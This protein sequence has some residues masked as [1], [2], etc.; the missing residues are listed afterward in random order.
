MNKKIKALMSASLLTTSVLGLSAQSY[1]SLWNTVEESSAKDQPRQ[2]FEDAMK[3]YM[4]AA[5]EG[6]FPQMMKAWIVVSE[7]KCI[8][9]ADSF[10]IEILPEVKCKTP[11]EHSVYNAI[12]G[13][14][15]LAMCGASTIAYDEDTQQ[16]YR[17]KSAECFRNALADKDALVAAKATDYLPVVT[18]GANSR[19][20]GNDMYSVITMFVADY[21]SWDDDSVNVILQ[22]A[23]QYYKEHGNLNAS[24]LM[25]LNL[26]KR[27]RYDMTESCYLTA[28][29]Q[30]MNESETIEAGA[31]VAAEYLDAMDG[32]DVSEDDRWQFV[33]HAQDLFGKSTLK[34]CFV[35]AENEMK[36]S[37]CRLSYSSCRDADSGNAS[38]S[39]IYPN[40]PFC[41]KI[42]YENL[43]SADVEIREYDGRDNKGE[44][45]TSG[46]LVDKRH[47]ILGTDSTCQSRRK[48]GMPYEGTQ[49]ETVSLTAGRYVTVLK[50]NGKTSVD[51]L[52]VSSLCILALEQPR[53]KRLFIVVDNKTGKPISGATLHM[54]DRKDN[55]TKVVCDE[56]GRYFCDDAKIERI[57]ASISDNDQLDKN[58]IRVYSSWRQH[59]L[60]R[61]VKLYTDRTIYRPGQTVHVSGMVYTGDGKGW[62]NV[63]PNIK[64]E[65]KLSDVNGQEVECDTLKSNEW[66]TFDTE[67]VLPKDRLPGNYSIAISINGSC[68]ASDGI[69]VEEYKRPT[70]DVTAKSVDEG[71]E[72]AFGD[73]VQVRISAQTFAGVP[74]QGAAVKYIVESGTGRYRWHGDWEQTADGQTS[75]DSNGEAVVTFQTEADTTKLE[76]GDVVGYRLTAEVTDI[77]GETHTAEYR[78][79]LSGLGFSLQLPAKGKVDLS[80]PKD[81]LTVKALNPND[82]EMSVDGTYKIKRNNSESNSG[83][84]YNDSRNNN[85]KEMETVAEGPFETGKPISLASL[86]MGTYTIEVSA[87]DSHGHLVTTQR[88]YDI[89][90]SEEAVDPRTKIKAAPTSFDDNLYICSQPTFSESKPCEVLLAPCAD[91]I[92]V[93]YYI[94]SDSTVFEQKQIQ[95]NRHLYRFDIDYKPEYGEAV[96][97]VLAFVRNGQTFTKTQPI[98]YQRSDNRLQL[99]WKTFRDNLMPGQQE[100]WIL[101]V[102]DKDGNSVKAAEMMATMYDASLDQLAA[103]SWMFNYS[104]A[105]YYSPYLRFMGQDVADNL[106]LNFPAKN[107]TWNDHDYDRLMPFEYDGNGYFGFR[108]GRRKDGIMLS[109]APLMMSAKAVNLSMMEEESVGNAVDKSLVGRIAG[110]DTN[111]AS[112]NEDTAGT[113]AGKVDMSAS[114]RM[115]S[116]FNETA[117]FYP[118]LTTDADGDVHIAFTLPESLTTWRLLGMV[119]TKDI[120]YGLIDTTC[121]A[122]KNFMVQPN[123]PRFVRE[124]DKVSIVSRVIN[125]GTADLKSRVLFCLLDAESGKVVHNETKT[126]SV[127]A[128]QTEPVAFDYIVTD[129]YPLLVCEITAEAG[130]CSDGERNY[131]PVLTAKQYVTE[132]VPFYISGSESKTVDLSTLFN[133]NSPSATQRCMTLEYTANPACTVIEAL[134]GISVPDN[135][136]AISHAASLYA[137]TVASRLAQSIPGFKE[138]LEKQRNATAGTADAAKSASSG[139]KS[140]S[141]SEVNSVSAINSELADNERM[142]DIVLRESPW[143]RDAL[144][145]SDQ[146]AA[147]LDLFDENLM[148]QRTASAKEKL[149]DLQNADGSWSWFDGMAGS[150]YVTL[151]VCED[152]ALLDPDDSEVQ[153][154]L[155]RGMK[156]LDKEMYRLYNETNSDKTSV[157]N[158]GMHYLFV[159]SLLPDRHVSKDIRKMREEWLGKVETSVRDLTIYGK[160]NCACFLRTFGHTEVADEFLQSV[161]EYSVIK[162]GMGRYYATDAAYYSWCDYRIPTQL[163]VMRAV[164]QSQLADKETVLADMQVWLLRQK[165]TQMWD[166]PM[167][168]ISA[169][170]YLLADSANLADAAVP[171]FRMDG[172]NISTP[173]DTTKF[174]AQQLGYVHTEIDAQLTANGVTKLEIVPAKNNALQNGLQ[175]ASQANSQATSQSNPQATSQSNSQA[176]LQNLS[177]ISWGAV[178]ARFLENMDRLKTQSSG[179]LKIARRLLVD[180]KTFDPQTSMLKVGDRVTVRIT[181]TADRD[182]DFVQVHL[183][184]PACFESTD[185]SSGYRWMNGRGGYVAR[186]DASTDLFFDKFAK[187]N[188]TLDIDY[189]VTRTGEYLTGAATVQ[190]AYA[191]EF[192]GHTGS[193]SVK[194][195]E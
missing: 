139:A 76:L 124:G 147:L 100:E 36:Q 66:G 75:L 141:S 86:S 64:V 108:R 178:S 60:N 2:V 67:F 113:S 143:L 184:T 52:N 53:G 92:C 90:D 183:L 34:N 173:I 8:L 46:K 13:S 186:H 160:A 9:D 101:T 16:E 117:F 109:D 51:Q 17:D 169:V 29:K 191:P 154:M 81:I 63:T 30:L 158:T 114:N 24:T 105:Y 103:F 98:A 87:K 137:N 127:A 40:H 177:R 58:Y 42:D 5:D 153:A 22:D 175:K 172:K 194:V 106:W 129:Q 187:G 97:L 91:D 55:E 82:E 123:M 88:E 138:A 156:Y 168:T 189:Y 7:T 26:L 61:H 19:L 31:D 65:V 50:S 115:R 41:L 135:S 142:K 77:A 126:L 83:K 118:H 152:L 144:L 99:T 57:S 62:I 162:P 73:A 23:A 104:Y 146:R 179:E 33:K 3:I 85:S 28:V 71:K 68:V 193:I 116:N 1:S 119:H 47:L 48:K 171:Q 122:K 59:D 43:T 170:S 157:G 4:K 121:V 10:N 12:M 159:S 74:V 125:Q 44:L 165:Q 70:F 181:V 134:R 54:Y 136:S 45:K 95:L 14:A 120:K 49:I 149:T 163:A 69:Q 84:G 150:F 11:V 151:A 72:L 176:T 167:N 27:R 110:M 111:Q 107:L 96:T 182:M 164:R 155:E 192:S 25:Q 6:N 140:K 102:K 32:S 93:Y 78:V 133:G 20:W 39:F 79:Y 35:N 94:M 15:Y 148:R 145:E 180:G 80:D 37:L 195:C 89:Y 190:C 128:G 112:P 185:Q 21:S 38:D 161:M 174:L 132:T 18:K 56:T 166:N 188:V 131:L 130:N